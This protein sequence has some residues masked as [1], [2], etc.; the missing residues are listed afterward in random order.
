[1]KSEKVQSD[2][3]VDEQPA[4]HFWLSC[5]YRNLD[6]KQFFAAKAASTEQRTPHQLASKRV[7]N[8]ISTI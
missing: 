6:V 1:M 5:F 2:K 8:E 4:I 3:R 7:Y